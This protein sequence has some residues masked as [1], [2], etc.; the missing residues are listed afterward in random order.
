MNRQLYQQ[1]K[2]TEAVK[3]LKKIAEGIACGE[4]DIDFIHL[5][6]GLKSGLW[7]FRVA[8]QETDKYSDRLSKVSTDS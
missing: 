6:A 3:A 4:L 5:Q 7:E 8:L 1:K 2:N